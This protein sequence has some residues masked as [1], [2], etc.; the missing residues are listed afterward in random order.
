MSLLHIE[1]GINKLDDFYSSLA[2][3]SQDGK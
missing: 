1:M 3:L 2:G